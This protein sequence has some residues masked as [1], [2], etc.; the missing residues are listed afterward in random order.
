MLSPV[1]DTLV[2]GYRGLFAA[3]AVPI[4]VELARVAGVATVNGSRT[5]GTNRSA[6]GVVDRSSRSIRGLLTGIGSTPLADLLSG[7]LNHCRMVPPI[8]GCIS[9]APSP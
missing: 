6:V 1:T 2:R 7:P 3:D 8:L 5:S 4:T 9:M